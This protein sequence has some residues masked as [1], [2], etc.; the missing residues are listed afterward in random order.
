MMDRRLA[1]LIVVILLAVAPPVL[2]QQETV[3]F[4]GDPF[5][6]SLSNM[7][8]DVRDDQAGVSPEL[9]ITNRN[10]EYFWAS[11]DDAQLIHFE[12]GPHHVF[13]SPS[14]GYIKILDTEAPGAEPIPLPRGAGSRRFVYVAHR[15][16][17][18]HV[19][20][21]WGFGEQITPTRVGL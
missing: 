14:G 18:V 11:Q 8:E 13:I 9:V 16:E 10:G 7:E 5:T 3:V 17:G 1:L 21:T 6:R 4:R 2:A 15:I 20:T 19:L 12:D